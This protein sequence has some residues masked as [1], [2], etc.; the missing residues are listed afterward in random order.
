MLQ[1]FTQKCLEPILRSS[2][3]QTWKQGKSQLWRALKGSH[4]DPHFS[5]NCP[6]ATM[7]GQSGTVCE[8]VCVCKTSPS[9]HSSDV[10][11]SWCFLIV[12]GPSRASVWLAVL[13]CVFKGEALLG[14]GLQRYPLLIK[15]GLLEKSPF[16]SF[17]FNDFPIYLCKKPFSVGIVSNLC[18]KLCSLTD[19][20]PKLWHQSS[21][22]RTSLSP[23]KLPLGVSQSLGS[24]GKPANMF[25]CK[26]PLH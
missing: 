23:S 16:S 22:V 14:K 8:C 19:F 7:S 1:T 26:W 15:H 21:M 11:V 10:D 5:K 3:V 13:L 6:S 20:A 25:G 9:A 12:L 17:Y 18:W 4:V 2:D 24:T